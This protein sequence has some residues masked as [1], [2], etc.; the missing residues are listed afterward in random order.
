[1]AKYSGKPVTLN[2]SA[3]DVY[4]RVADLGSFQERLE[5]LPEEAR[6]KLGDVRFTSDSI[7]INAA[8]VGEMKF[9]LTERVPH[10]LLRFEAENSPV[11]FLITV[12]LK[13]L[14]DAKTEV[15]PVIDVEIPA[16]LRPLVGSKMQEAADKFGEMFTNMFSH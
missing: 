2:H 1:M 9:N 4:D 14:G 11:P 5:Q 3:A 16:M 15:S 13:D 12:N 6:A 7:I 8:P 10:S